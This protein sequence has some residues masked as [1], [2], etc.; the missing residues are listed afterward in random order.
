MSLPYY[1]QTANKLEGE[2]QTSLHTKGA[3]YA[4]RRVSFEVNV[5]NGNGEYEYKFSEVFNGKRKTIQEYSSDNKYVFIIDNVGDHVYYVDFK[6]S[7]GKKGT[8]SYTIKVTK[9]PNS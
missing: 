7:D 5:K 4:G 3:E 1:R 2:L 8:L 6:D 9:R